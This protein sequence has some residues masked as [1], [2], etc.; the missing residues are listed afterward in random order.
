MEYISNSEQETEAF[1]FDFAKKTKTGDIIIL[2]GDMGAGKTA[3]VRGF[4]KFFDIPYVSSPT[5][6]IVNEYEG[7]V[8]ILHFDLYR[9]QG[10]EELFEIGF[11]DYL[12]QDA[13]IVIEWPHIAISELDRSYYTV[14][15]E[16]VS[17]NIRRITAD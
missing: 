13:I 11:E 1:A 8:R 5:F 15:I 4:C 14:N 16:R 17:E 9:L 2:N 10:S 3:F 6:N 12:S 7:K